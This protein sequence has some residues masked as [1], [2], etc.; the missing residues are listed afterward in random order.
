MLYTTMKKIACFLSI[1]LIASGEL[2]FGQ[3]INMSSESVSKILC[4]QWE[5]SYEKDMY[6]GKRIEAKNNEKFNFEFLNNNTVKLASAYQKEKI[7]GTWK[8][9]PNKK[10]IK[11]SVNNAPP[12]SDLIIVSLSENEF[13][14]LSQAYS[15]VAHKSIEIKDIFIPKQ[16][17]L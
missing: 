8:Y 10:I 15:G 11:I 12:D 14:I 13:T 2:L 7:N 16:N 6:S 9:Y 17:L 5:Y 1:I 4:K 3:D